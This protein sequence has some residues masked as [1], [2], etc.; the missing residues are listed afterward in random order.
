MSIQVLVLNISKIPSQRPFK[1]LQDLQSYNLELLFERSLR[2][3]YKISNW[4]LDDLIKRIHDPN[5][6]MF[7]SK[8]WDVLRCTVMSG[9][10]INAVVKCSKTFLICHI[11]SHEWPLQM[12]NRLNLLGIGGKYHNK[13]LHGDRSEATTNINITFLTTHLWLLSF[14]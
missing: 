6:V 5:V 14:Y 7:K 11:Y 8:S 1:K 13:N 3:T 2:N 10:Y 4:H 9:F 12:S